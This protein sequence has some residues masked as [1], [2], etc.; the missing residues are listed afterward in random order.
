MRHPRSVKPESIA[1][2]EHAIQIV[3][4]HKSLKTPV[5]IDFA[6]VWLQLNRTLVIETFI[7]AVEKQA[8]RR[9]LRTI[10]VASTER[11]DAMRDLDVMGVTAAALFPGVE[12]ACRALAEKWF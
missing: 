6:A 9:F 3:D 7:E 1:N 10:D 4:T 12:G 5:G 2:A 11:A 8:G